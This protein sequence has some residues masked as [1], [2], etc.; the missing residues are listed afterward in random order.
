MQETGEVGADSVLVGVADLQAGAVDFLIG[1]VDSYMLAGVA[2]FLTEA[3]DLQARVDFQTGEADL[4]AGV[5]F[6][7]GVADLQTGV[8]VAD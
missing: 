7:T 3:A 1:M 4:S 8:R 6:L 2:G 5:D